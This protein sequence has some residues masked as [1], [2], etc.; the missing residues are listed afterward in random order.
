MKKWIFLLTT[1]FSR[2]VFGSSIQDRQIDPKALSEL[3]S[4]L[5]IPEN[6]DIIAE[7][8]QRWLRGS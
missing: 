5:G 6:A 4:T 1:C 3:T 7:T 2:I 8:Q